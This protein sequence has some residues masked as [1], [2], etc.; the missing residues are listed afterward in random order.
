MTTQPVSAPTPIAQ[1]IIRIATILPRDIEIEC[2]TPDA[3]TWVK[4]NAPRY[5]ILHDLR[6]IDGCYCLSV[7]ELYDLQEVARYIAQEIGAV[8]Q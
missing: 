8:I 3:D 5:G 4:S 6:D 2:A 1:A 7:S